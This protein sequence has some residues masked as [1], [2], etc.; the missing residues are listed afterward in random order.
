LLQLHQLLQRLLAMSARPQLFDELHPPPPGWQEPP[1]YALL[2]AEQQQQQQQQQRQQRPRSGGSG[3]G[4][5]N[6]WVPAAA[7]GCM[8]DWSDSSGRQLL[9]ALPAFI[10]LLQ[11]VACG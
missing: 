1:P 3:R 8:S 2:L 5:V 4:E 7:A 10:P 11:M 6:S 9:P